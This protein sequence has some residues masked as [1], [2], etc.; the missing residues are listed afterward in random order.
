[1]G[2]KNNLP[3]NRINAIS[4]LISI[5]LSYFLFLFL[6][7]EKDL[8]SLFHH[9][10]SVQIESTAVI[11]EENSVVLG[12]PEQELAIGQPEIIGTSPRNTTAVSKS[13]KARRTLDKIRDE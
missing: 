8:D 3:S 7:G 11:D 5:H 4:V 2:I 6:K 1:M 10:D 9:A 13:N 12:F